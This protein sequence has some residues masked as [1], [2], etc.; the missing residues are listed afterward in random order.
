MRQQEKKHDV[1]LINHERSQVGYESARDQTVELQALMA[2]L[3]GSVDTLLARLNIITHQAKPNTVSL[4]AVAPSGNNLTVMG[5][6][7]SYAEAL[8]YAA[9]L[10][11]YDLIE[12]ARTV[13]I[14]GSSGR[15]V[16]EESFA[17]FQVKITLPVEDEPEE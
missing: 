9:N 5:G 12:D 15:K 3:G 10:R 6:A 11:S 14:Q 1:I 4:L 7:Q 13:Q 17:N 2:D 16:D 8:R